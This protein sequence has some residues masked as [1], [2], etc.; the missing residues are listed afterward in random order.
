MEIQFP[1]THREAII[2]MMPYSVYVHDLKGDEIYVGVMA[3]CLSQR[4]DNHEIIVAWRDGSLL[5]GES[6]LHDDFAALW[7]FV[8]C[9]RYQC[10]QVCIYNNTNKKHRFRIYGYR[11]R[12]VI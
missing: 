3:E 5:F 6:E 10:P 2:T 9:T 11:L 7:S 1:E 4:V 12:R 8:D